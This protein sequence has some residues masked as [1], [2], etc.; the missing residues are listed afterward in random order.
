VAGSCEYDNEPSVSIKSWDFLT[1]RVTVSFSRS[2]PLHWVSQSVSQSVTQFFTCFNVYHVK[3]CKWVDLCP[4]GMM[5]KR[6]VNLTGI[7][8]KLQKLIKRTNYTPGIEFSACTALRTIPKDPVYRYHFWIPLSPIKCD[9]IYGCHINE[10]W[11]NCL[12]QKASLMND[13]PGKCVV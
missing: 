9:I 4:I 6:R 3:N 2:I 11:V 13:L 5:K 12:T 7:L 10:A 1:S 8:L